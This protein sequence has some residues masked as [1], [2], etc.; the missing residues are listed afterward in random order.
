MSIK[1]SIEIV[2]VVIK[3][4]LDNLLEFT[5]CLVKYLLSYRR[6]S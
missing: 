4:G 6:I 3:T 1:N 5:D 2:E